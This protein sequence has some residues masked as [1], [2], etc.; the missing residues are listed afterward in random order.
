NGPEPRRSSFNFLRRQKSGEAGGKAG[1]KQRALDE[2]RLRREHAALPRA[3][4]KLPS[5]SPLPRLNAFG[6]RPDSYAIVSNQHEQHQRPHQHRSMPAAAGS[7]PRNAP[8]PIP[9]IP[10]GSPNGA[11]D[12]DPY[13]RTESMTHRGRYSYAS[14]AVSTLNSPRRVRRRRDPTPFNVLVVGT[15]N[16][17]KTSFINFLRTALAL[18][19]KKQQTAASP[20]QTAVNPESPFTSYYLESE[21]DNERIGVTLW[22]S[23]GLER[24]IVDL[25]L[26]EM[27]TFLESKFEET[28]TEE[29]KVIRAPGVR[30]THIHCVFLVLD[31]IRL[32]SNI[33]TSRWGSNPGGKHGVKDRVIGGLDQDLDLQVLRTLQGK[34]TVIPVISKA[35]TITT[36]HMTYLKKTVWDSL[37]QARLDPLEA[38]NLDED[39]DD[40]R[41]DE[42]ALDERDEDEY[43]LSGDEQPTDDTPADPSDSDEAYPSAESPSPAAPA[44]A[45]AAD[46]LPYLPLSVI[47]PDAYE[48]GA[49]GR[50]FPWGFADPYDPAHCDFVRLKESVFAEWRAEL[51]EASR[52]RWYEGWRAS[53]LE[54]Q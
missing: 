11:A 53:R 54:E 42:Q 14:S 38:L 6:D 37:K 35:D 2:E 30:D 27:S 49:V 25:Q 41:E 48:P 31:P 43:N 23:K 28:F 47:S 13:A 33:A 36:A 40:E 16:S 8:I 45:P 9:P 29:Q 1:R 19:P 39:D 17:G 15:K 51:R 18:P 4:P 10:A 22:D 52:A 21:I 3:P 32:D 50:R 20:P 46:A 7:P 26:R 24:N 5:Y 44:S 34:T 12:F